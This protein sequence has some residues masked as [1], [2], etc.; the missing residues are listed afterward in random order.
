MSQ[1]GKDSPPLHSTRKRELRVT[2][3]LHKDEY[4]DV[5]T[6]LVVDI[7]KGRGKYL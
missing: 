1:A 4:F 3:V 6:D 2:T 7:R 5:V